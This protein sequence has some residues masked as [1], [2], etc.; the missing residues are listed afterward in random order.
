MKEFQFYNREIETLDR[1]SLREHQSARLRWLIKD[2]STN[3][4]FAARLASGE[5]RPGDIR[6]VDDLSAIPFTTKADLVREQEENPPFGDLLSYP[7][8][9]YRYFHQTS[10]TS[11]RPLRCLDTAEDWDWWSRCWGYVFRAAGVSENDIV[12]CAFSFGPYLSHWAAIYGARHIGSLA[13][14][15]GGM[16]SQLRL[17]TM[18]DTGCTAIVCTPTYA[19]HLA[20]VAAAEGIDLR[21]SKV[22]L[23]IHAGEPGASLPNVKKALEEAW[24]YSCFDHAGAT[25][26]G[27][28][29]FECEAQP[30]AIHV[31]EAEFIL[32]LINPSDLSPCRVGDRGEV[33][34]TSLG[35]K[36]MPCVRY[37][38]G[39]LAELA[40]GDCPCG[41]RFA[42]IRGGLLG[43]ADEMFIIRGVNL[44]PSAIDDLI[45]GVSGVVEYEVS[46]RQ[47]AGLD[48]LIVRVEAHEG[49]YHQVSS[50]LKEQFRG[51]FGIRL[52]V[53][54][55]PTGSLP[56]YE[57][58]ARR[59]RTTRPVE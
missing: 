34:I 49:T 19:L 56:R 48:D 52:S 10:G 26:V 4:V 2:I 12:F 40:G 13:I 28:W 1:D 46:V 38:T 23:G 41:R 59:F 25:E 29:A 16:S 33:V 58:K 8:S 27:A 14:P 39:D 42:R 36:G 50:A 57:F 3:R 37:R 20:E 31:N 5:V 55:A 15:G 17:R 21:A 32:E 7:V 11:G 47:V 9:R 6:G 18:I 35:R 30:G 44:Y 45:R 24:G 43:R 22:R 54:Q 53:E 51:S